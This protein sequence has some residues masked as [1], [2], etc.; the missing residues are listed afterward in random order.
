MFQKLLFYTLVVV[1]FDAMMY[2]FSNKKY[3]GHIELKHYF[4][5]LKMPI[6]QKS[7]VTKILIVQIFLIITMA[8]TN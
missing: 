8:F 7:L 6:Y 4:A 3:R 5:V 2:M 1:T